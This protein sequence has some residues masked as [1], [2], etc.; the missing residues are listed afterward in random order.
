MEFIK[1]PNN[2]LPANRETG[3]HLGEFCTLDPLAAPNTFKKEIVKRKKS[4]RCET[5]WRFAE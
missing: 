1:Q 2:L 4:S 5:R 3:T